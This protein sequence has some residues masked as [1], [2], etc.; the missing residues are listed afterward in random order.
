VNVSPRLKP[1]LK[2]DPVFIRSVSPQVETPLE[3]SIEIPRGARPG[4]Y[5]GEIS[6]KRGRK[7]LSQRLP[8]SIQILDNL[9]PMAE[10]GQDQLVAL[11]EGETTVQV[12]LDASSSTDPDGTIVSHI[13]IGT[14]DPE[15]VVS[16][17]VTL[18]P[19]IHEFTLQVTDDKGATAL[20]S[21]NVTVLGPPL[22]MPLPEVT[23]ERTV[24]L[25]GISLPGATI[26]LTN[27]TTGETKEIL[28]ENG[29]FEAPFDLTPG[30]NEFQSSAKIGDVQ[31]SPTKL[32]ITYAITRTLHLDSVS[33]PEGQ[34]GSIVTLTG[35]GFTPDANIMGVHFIGSEIEGTGSRLEGKG[36]VLQASETELQVI[37][38]FIFLKS[39]EDIEVYVYDGHS[40]SNSV[41]FHVLTAQDPTPGIKG[42]EAVYQLELITIQLQHLFNK[43]EQWTKP[44]VPPETWA[45]IEENIRRTQYFLETFKE[46]VN[47][48]PSEE[49]RA[50][51]DAIFGGEFFSLVTQQLEQANEILSHTTPCDIA[52]VIQI[53][54]EILEPINTLNRVLDGIKHTLIA[55]QVGNGIACFFGCVPCCA[56]IPFLYEVYSTVCAIDSVVDAIRSVFNTVITMMQ[57][58]VPTIPSEWKVAISGPFPGISN[59]ILYTDTSSEI[60]LYANFTNAGFEQLINMGNL[61]IDIPDPGGVFSILSY[62]GIDIEA[63]IEEEL[64]RLVFDLSVDLL[65]IDEIRITFADI[66]VSST[67]REQADPSRL[68]TVIGEGGLRESHTIIAGSS[69]GTGV[70][71]NIQ[72]SCGNYQYPSRTK[73]IRKSFRHLCRLGNGLSTYFRYRGHTR[74]VHP[75]SEMGAGRCLGPLLY[76]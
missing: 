73:C 44:N 7:I 26:L 51:L 1:F 4:L 41:T 59:H 60:R 37:V 69:S 24:T 35:S 34:S 31:S 76:L 61:R 67:V 68:V 8:V 14:P 49:V 40:M 66:N 13:W 10:A 19:G 18:K 53:L 47:S 38:P 42:N 23:G 2:T 30:L 71:L 27:S 62:I 58:A 5:S 12:R 29:L 75:E 25:K 32:K 64:G 72:A 46:R 21:V 36:V 22:L 50:N 45:L 17:M 65:D 48:I 39:E 33:P 15:D 28:N 55:I 9:A 70:L 11:P 16:P 6:L 43:L 3:I 74:S 20:D 63:A 54:N 52:R 56:A 57:A